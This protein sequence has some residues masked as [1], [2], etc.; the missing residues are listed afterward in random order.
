[1]A[2]K[3]KIHLDPQADYNGSNLDEL[4]H[5]LIEEIKGQRLEAERYDE[6]DPFRDYIEG[7]IAAREVVLGRL[8]VSSELWEG[9][10]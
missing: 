2:S 3:N 6:N 9:N 5:L 4:C 8:G 10:A 7:S 1:M